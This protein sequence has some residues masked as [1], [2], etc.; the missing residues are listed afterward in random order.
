[1][2]GLNTTLDKRF[3]AAT[4]RASF[5]NTMNS[6]IYGQESITN[7]EA[8]G[9]DAAAAEART[10]QKLGIQGQGLTNAYNNA[11]RTLASGLANAQL[12]SNASSQIGGGIMGMGMGSMGGGGGGGFSSYGQMASHT[13][14]GTTGSYQQGMG[15]VPKATAA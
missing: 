7:R 10:N 2:V 3:D 4:N 9:L 1:M 14:P 12:V 11:N 13:A 15:W 8:A 5:L 6:N